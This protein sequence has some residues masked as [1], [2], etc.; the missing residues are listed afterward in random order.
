MS[1]SN[2]TSDGLNVKV[3]QLRMTCG[4]TDSVLETGKGCAIN[5]QIESL[6]ELSKEVEKSHRVVELRK[7]TEGE[8]EGKFAEWNVGIEGKLTEADENIKR[9]ESWLLNCKIEKD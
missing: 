9:L 7:I 3:K 2:D 5:R 6:K 8:E 1:E 4:R